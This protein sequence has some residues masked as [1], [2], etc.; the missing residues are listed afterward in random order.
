VT[1]VG[2]L[3][4]TIAHEMT[5]PLMAI[6]ANGSA[7]QRLLDRKATDDVRVA[8][9]EIV[10]DAMRAAEVVRSVGRL[11]RKSGPEASPV[12]LGLVV[13]EVVRLTR[14][15]AQTAGVSLEQSGSADAGLVIGDRAQLKQVLL[16]LVINAIEAVSPM[17]GDKTVRVRIA[18]CR[19]GSVQVDVQDNGP[20]V[21]VSIA[22][23]LF[24]PL[25]TTKSSGRSPDPVPCRSIVE[26]HGGTLSVAPAAPQGVIFTFALPAAP[27]V[28]IA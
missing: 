3:V 2:E 17:A 20:G 27:P 26:A 6:V 9:T 24:E 14:T 28:C 22:P 4:A 19:D 1:T 12:N 16:N 13:Q 7:S 21:D 11:M 25:V 10:D 18:R 23:S 5:Q 8:L 15:Q